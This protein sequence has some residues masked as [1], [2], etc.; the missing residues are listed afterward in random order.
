M[1][2]L[3]DWRGRTVVCIASGPSLT[4]ADC[5]LVRV[6][7]HIVMVTNTTFRACP[8]A[9]ALYVFDP[10]W[11]KVHIAE[12]RETFH[13]LLITQSLTARKGVIC[14]QLDPKFRSFGNA[15]AC[16]VSMAICAGSR[17][18][19]L[20]AYDCGLG[21]NGETHHH[22]DHADGLRNCDT[23]PRWPHQFERLARYAT[24]RGAI[25]LN[26]SRVSSLSCFPRV[27]LEESLNDQ[28]GD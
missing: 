28:L 1:I 9:D 16:A 5:E 26:A 14:A 3:P 23:M 11:W 15:G 17:R 19:I 4:P 12:V 8:W 18:V 7:G 13:G 27:A 20:L 6:S 10:L 22:G 21:P 2:K 24:G 25:V